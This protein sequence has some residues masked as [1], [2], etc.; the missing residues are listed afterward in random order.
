MSHGRDFDDALD[1]AV[2]AQFI[3]LFSVLVKDVSTPDKALE[4]F[5]AGLIHLVK[6]ETAVVKLIRDKEV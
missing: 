2:R 4:R 1:E 5:E 6:T 3:H